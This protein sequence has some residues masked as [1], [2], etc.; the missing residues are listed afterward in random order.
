MRTFHT[1]DRR[2]SRERQAALWA[3]APLLQITPPGVEEAAT[4]LDVV[5][6]IP[7]WVPWALGLGGA[8][9]L[10]LAALILVMRKRIRQQT[11]ELTAK[12]RQLENEIEERRRVEDALREGHMRLGILNRVLMRLAHSP[13]LSRGNWLAA[14]QEITQS[15]ADTLEIER[16]SIWLYDERH[17]RI[18]CLD[19]YERSKRSHTSGAVLLSRDYPAY[20]TALSYDRTLAAH[21]ARTDPR[22]R[23]FN[24]S[25]LEP[26]GI[27]SMLDAPIR[28]SGR[29]IGVVCHEHIGQPRRWTPEEEYFA[30]S[31]ADFIALAM[32]SGERREAE[33]ELRQSEERNRAVIENA[34]DAVI[35]ADETGIITGWNAQ[36]EATFGCPREEAIGRSIHSLIVPPEYREACEQGFRH[37]LITG[38]RRGLISRTEIT[39]LTRNGNPFP[40]E[41]SVS[42]AR[43]GDS[44]VFSAFI[45]DITE[46]KHATEVREKLLALSHELNLARTIQSSILPRA[47]PQ[48]ADLELYAQMIPAQEVA[49]DFYDFFELDPHRI[50]MVIGDVSGKGVPAAIFMAMCRTIVRASALS[51][52]SA[53]ECLRHAN[54]LLCAESHS[55]YFV[56]LFYGILNTQDGAVEYCSAGHLSPYLLDPSGKATLLPKAESLVLGVAERAEYR[57]GTLRLSPGESLLLYTD[58]VTEAMDTARSLYRE[59]RLE[60]FLARAPD[61]GMAELVAGIVKDVQEFST[62]APQHDDITVLACRYRGPT[63]SGAALEHAE[64]GTA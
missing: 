19:L 2:P 51:G 39:A 64:A 13:N 44:M 28:K 42:S 26:L 58:G 62:G 27:T 21:D 8:L 16:V 40:A 31:L 3:A 30:G 7:L 20:F 9:L 22:T 53:A 38:E 57:C 56:T 59:E 5:T 6:Y 17:T 35:T 52:A 11:A 63:Q 55:G 49:G 15:A 34:L 45:R 29:M 47:F 23:E 36:A 37:V 54:R 41:L 48:R 1:V 32:E 43:V 61:A 24:E 46:R 10:I 18:E 12:N 25:Y 60:S 14:L 33:Y 4:P 50:G